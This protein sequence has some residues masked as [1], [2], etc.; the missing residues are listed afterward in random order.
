MVY[1]STRIFVLSTRPL[2]HGVCVPANPH[3]LAARRVEAYRRLFGSEP[4]Q[5]LTHDQFQKP[6]FGGRLDV[7]LYEMAYERETGQVQVAVTSGMSDY[8]MTDNNSDAPP[9][10]RELIQYF[11]DCKMLDLVRLHDMA[12]VP[13]AQGF[14]L[15][16]FHTVGS[17]PSFNSAW[18]NALFLP[19]LVQPHAE[20]EL[21]LGGGEPMQL[22]WHVP[23]SQAELDYKTANGVNALLKR[24]GEVKLPWIFDENNRPALI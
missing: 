6:A 10:R 20:F 3:Q 24:M 18:P 17:Y 4:I 8:L 15:D 22:L 16:F 1:N 7:H 9:R 23:L 13:L 2:W 21:D 14:A 12:W 11:R 19:S 5:V